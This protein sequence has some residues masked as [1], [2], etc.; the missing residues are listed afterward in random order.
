VIGNAKIPFFADKISQ[1][2]RIIAYA[3]VSSCVVTWLAIESMRYM[4]ARRTTRSLPQ[5]PQIE[6]AGSLFKVP[7]RKPGGI[8][9]LNREK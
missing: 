6:K 1:N 2:P 3:V 5:T 8:S 9:F 4:K 7:T